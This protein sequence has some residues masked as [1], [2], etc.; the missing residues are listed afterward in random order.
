MLGSGSSD[1][2]DQL[3]EQLADN[4]SRKIASGR[5]LMRIVLT[6]AHETCLLFRQFEAV[7]EQVIG[8]HLDRHR[9]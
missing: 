9:R 8:K 6:S 7:A 2:N 3:A 1:Y 5:D 4:S